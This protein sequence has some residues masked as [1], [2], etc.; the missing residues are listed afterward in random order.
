MSVCVLGSG[1]GA[2]PLQRAKQSRSVL[3]A[4]GLYGISWASLHPL[5]PCP[6]TACTHYAEGRKAAAQCVLHSST[7]IP[8]L[9]NYQNNNAIVHGATAYA[10]IVRRLLA[11]LAYLLLCRWGCTCVSVLVPS[12]ELD[13]AIT[14][15]VVGSYTNADGE[16]CWRMCVVCVVLMSN[17]VIIV[18]CEVFVMP[19]RCV[20]TGA[21]AGPSNQSP[22]RTTGAP[23]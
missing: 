11:I 12:L 19:K 8:A 6:H 17:M 4:A 2:W 16:M 18:P 21:G 1:A 7:S 20:A 3:G 9:T 15:A 23:S 13:L 22:A 10:G 14:A 5:G